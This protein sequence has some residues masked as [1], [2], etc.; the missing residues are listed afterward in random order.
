MPLKWVTGSG[1]AAGDDDGL[2]HQP[3]QQR[4]PATLRRLRSA[5][6]PSPTAA[7]MNTEGDVTAAQT[8]QSN[9]TVSNSKAVTT[10][11]GSKVSA[12]RSIGSLF[13]KNMTA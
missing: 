9:K 6:T 5:F 11:T 8:P 3:Q 2:Q 1:C 7:A 13:F 10:S 4:T 12:D